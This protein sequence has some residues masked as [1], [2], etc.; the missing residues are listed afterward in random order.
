MI[1]PPVRLRASTTLYDCLRCVICRKSTFRPS[2]DPVEYKIP[3]IN[4]IQVNHAT[5]LDFNKGL[6]ALMR[7]DPDVI[8]VGRNS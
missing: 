5:G 4:H 7:Q 1:L 3:G 8:L 2:E 6:R